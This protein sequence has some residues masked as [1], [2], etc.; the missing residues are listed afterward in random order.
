M[1]FFFSKYTVFWIWDWGLAN[2]FW[3]HVQESIS[4]LDRFIFNIYFPNYVKLKYSVEAFTPHS[5]TLTF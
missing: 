2:S 3:D 4:R 5:Q 1:F